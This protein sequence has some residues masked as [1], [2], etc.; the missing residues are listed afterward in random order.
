M[1]HFHVLP[2]GAL[3][4]EAAYGLGAEFGFGIGPACESFDLGIGLEKLEM[5]P[6]GDPFG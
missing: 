3:P 1:L 6:M 5:G 2:A 4:L